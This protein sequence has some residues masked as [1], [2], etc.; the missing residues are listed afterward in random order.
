M[1]AR[2][3]GGVAIN[4]SVIARLPEGKPRN[5]VFRSKALAPLN[6]NNLFHLIVMLANLIIK[7]RRRDR[8]WQRS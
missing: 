8:L 2:R 5:L 6:V 3:R 4:P 1:R 7:A